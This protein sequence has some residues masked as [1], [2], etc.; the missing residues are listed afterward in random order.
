MSKHTTEKI[1]FTISGAFAFMTIAALLFLLFSIVREGAHM[2]SWSFI[3]EPP[4]RNMTEGGIWPALVG[5]FYVASLTI[6]ISVP[7]GIGAAIYLNE[8][9][10]QGPI[11]RIIR[12]SI[13]NLAGVPSIVYGLFGLA[14]F[15]STLR[16]GVGLITAAI[17]LAIMVLPWVITAS[18]EALKA[19]PRSFR[20]GG[21]AL[22]ATKWQTIRQLVLPTAIPGMATGS[23]LG[24]ARAAGETA[25]IILTGA[26]YFSRNLPSSLTDSFMALPYHLYILATQHAQ[27]SVVR[28]IAYGTALVL[29][30]M[31]ILL[32]MFAIL[33]RNYYRRKNE[34]L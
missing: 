29:I 27:A 22:G 13:R 32:N 17:T 3:T 10:K 23:I 9:A 6:L 31:V 25:P 5:T 19:V 30:L 12:M 7:V 28:P 21:L 16:I 4:R 34:V 20:E 26:A 8:Y 33:L 1:W 18:E 15:A 14:I 24:L 2:L 11:V